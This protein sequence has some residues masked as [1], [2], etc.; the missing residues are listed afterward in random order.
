MHT[1]PGRR[2]RFSRPHRA[3]RSRRSAFTLIE[4]LVVIGI[5]AILIG[6]LLPTLSKAREAA[7]LIKCINNEKQHVLATVIFTVDHR[8]SMPWTNWDGGTYDPNSPFDAG[9]L[10]RASTGG[11]G[12]WSLEH[13]QLFQYVGI[14]EMW[15]C[16]MDDKPEVAL[17]VREISSYV[18]NG[19]ISA[20]AR[21]RV[22]RISD[23]RSDAVMFWELDENLP[24]G[25][26]NDGANWPAEV[27]TA[28]HSGGGTYG[29][30]DGRAAH[31][32][33]LQWQSWLNDGP[34]PLY[35]DPSREDGGMA[36]DP[37]SG[38]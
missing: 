29:G 36:A 3:S 24:A 12:N 9:W 5:I 31:A 27:V 28:R 10:Y 22:F 33:W 37:Y 18:M 11:T 21:Q 15:R 7:M 26:W 16:P 17:G 35:C 20:F 34:G 2:H 32:P 30:F 23:F 38:V 13:G 8:D 19:A 25:S 4:L 1:H 14:D 6:I